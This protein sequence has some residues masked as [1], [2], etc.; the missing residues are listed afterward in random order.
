MCGVLNR[1]VG[2]ALVALA[3]TALV[4]GE[5][6]AQIPPTVTVRGV[7]YDSLRGAPLPGAFIALAGSARTAVS[8][9]RGRFRF[10]SVPP[11]THTFAMQHDVLD[12][13]GFSGRSARVSVDATNNSVTIAVPSFATLWR[14]LCG[15]APPRD[16]GIVYGVVRDLADRPV[17]GA[18]VG[19]TWQA[20]SFARQR[21]LDWRDMGGH[22]AADSTG[23]YA[24]C[25]VPTDVALHLAATK[26]S[27]VSAII[28]LTPIALRLARRDLRLAPDSAA[29]GPVERGIVSGTLTGEGAKPMAGAIVSIAGVPEVRSDDSGRFVMRD[30]PAGTRQIDVRAIGAAPVTAIVD[31][32]ASDTTNVVLE[33]GRVQTLE[34]IRVS[35]PTF[36]QVMIRNINERRLA[37]LGYVRDSTDFGKLPSMAPALDGVAGLRVVRTRGTQFRLVNTRPTCG[38]PLAIWIDRMRLDEDVLNSLRPDEIAT[39][40]VFLSGAN[41]PPE[42]YARGTCGAVAVWT[43][44][45]L[46]G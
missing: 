18:A 39:I 36:R 27:L 38:A 29:G 9:A 25:G 31:V 10:D 20:V 30:V 16:S 26:D 44:R 8:D 40:E 32:A 43:K 24:L 35:A 17:A 37:G 23:R 33:L 41:T 14:G 12:S 28:D 19:V 13:I 6:R 22:A 3:A 7:A 15:G 42:F 46:R 34:T 4:A 21:G 11:G 2:P 5:L 45:Y 1:R